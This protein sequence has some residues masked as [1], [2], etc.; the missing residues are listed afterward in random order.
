MTKQNKIKDMPKGQVYLTFWEV[1][2]CVDETIGSLSTEH[3]KEL[4]RI[5]ETQ[6]WNNEIH[7]HKRGSN[8]YTL[9]MISLRYV[10]RNM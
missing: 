7:T 4:R 5:A 2:N 9:S 6:L 3:I 8:C 10:Y 1:R